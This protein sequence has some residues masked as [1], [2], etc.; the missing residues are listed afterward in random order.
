MIVKRSSNGARPPE[1]GAPVAMLNEQVEYAH[2]TEREEVVRAT[3]KVERISVAVMLPHTVSTAEQARLQRL[4]SA[5]AGLDVSRGDRLEMALAPAPNVAR[6]LNGMP[7]RAAVSEGDGTSP[8][9]TPQWSRW[10]AWAALPAWLLGLVMGAVLL[11]RRT[12]A[13]RLLTATESEAAARK[14]RVWLA[15]GTV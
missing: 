13:P 8:A 10:L 12:Q 1:A 3:G 9:T 6:N 11:R 14:I 15:D 7:D 2:G 5:A 4:L